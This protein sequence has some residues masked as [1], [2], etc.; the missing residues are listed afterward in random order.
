MIVRNTV[1]AMHDA[2]DHGV[3]PGRPGGDIAILR[4]GC[5]RLP[6]T[7][8]SAPGDVDRAN[9]VD[10]MAGKHHAL[11]PAH[12]GPAVAGASLDDGVQ[13]TA[14]LEETARLFVLPLGADTRALS[15]EQ[16]RVVQ[17]RF[18]PSA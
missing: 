16:V 1:P 10:E 12:H 15:A 5:E 2:D 9:T 17:A 18:P 3:H 7:P 8:Y 4:A 13:V 6:L 11:L 14:A